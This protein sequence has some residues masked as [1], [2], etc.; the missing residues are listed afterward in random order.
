MGPLISLFCTSC[1]ICP[2]FQK[3]GE[4]CKLHASS[5]A[6]NKFFRY[7]SMCDICQLLASHRGSWTPCTLTFLADWHSNLLSYWNYYSSATNGVTVHLIDN[8]F[9]QFVKDGFLLKC[10]PSQKAKCFLF[11]TKGCAC[12]SI[13]E[14]YCVHVY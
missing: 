1:D 11:S 13:F 9:P 14:M 3:Q 5:P 12:R 7:I 8:Y 2:E 6:C 4:S 10:V